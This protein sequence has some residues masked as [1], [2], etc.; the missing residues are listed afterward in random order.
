MDSLRLAVFDRSPDQA[1]EIKSL[2]RNSGINVRIE[3][4]ASLIDAEHLF[5]DFK[6]LLVILNVYS[7]EGSDASSILDLASDHGVRAAVRISPSNLAPLAAILAQQPIL[8]LNSEEND[9]LIRLVGSLVENAV[10]T[11]GLQALEA[12]LEELQYRY[13]LLLENSSECIAYVHEGLH[14][15]A[16]SAYLELLGAVEFADIAAASLLEFMQGVDVDLKSVL[17]AMNDG[18]MPEK[19]AK[20]EIGSLTGESIAA[21][22][23]FSAARFEGEECVQVLAQKFSAPGVMG[24]QSLISARDNG[25]GIDPPILSPAANPVQDSHWAERIQRALDNRHVYVAQFP[26]VNLEEDAEAL[27]ENKVFLR[28]ESNDLSAEDFMP[29]AIRNGLGAMIDRHVIRGLVASISETEGRH[30]VSISE[31]SLLDFSFPAWLKHQLEESGTEGSKLVL[32]F[33]APTVRGRLKSLVHLAGELR[34]TGIRFALSCLGGD[35]GDLALLGGMDFAYARLQNGLGNE[36]E[37]DADNQSA[38]RKI[39]DVAN[40]SGTL[41]IAGEISNSAELAS[42]WQSGV[43]LVTGNYLKET[44][45]VAG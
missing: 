28:E 11:R 18:V 38:V 25:V 4:A 37:G 14:V 39:V 44:H 33:D 36:M 40:R 45:Q 24:E 2:L 30:L 32:Q 12:R 23:T 31:N 6:P 8:I 16:N 34:P 3:H 5:I 20:V 26:V 17:R 22:L 15:Y 13:N 27:F 42:L 1:E 10:E 29:A 7:L 9:Q 19:P 35:E 41:V 21:E 43:T